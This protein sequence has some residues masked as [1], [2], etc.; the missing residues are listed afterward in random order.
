MTELKPCP[1]CG[2]TAKVLCIGKKYYFVTCVNIFCPSS[3]EG[4]STK[5]EAIDQWN[6]RVKE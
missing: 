3:T 2:E 1:F 5:Q 4:V 6:R